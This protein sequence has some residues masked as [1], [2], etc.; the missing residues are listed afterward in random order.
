MF[1]TLC[2]TT[3]A[4]RRLSIFSISKLGEQKL[5]S[6]SKLFGSV[7]KNKVSRK[8]PNSTFQFCD[9]DSSYIFFFQ[10]C[11]SD[12]FLTSLNLDDQQPTKLTNS[13]SYN[14]FK[15]CQFLNTFF[16]FQFLNTFFFFE[17]FGND[18]DILVQFSFT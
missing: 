1:R 6:T 2:S 5:C 14:D 10:I 16:F 17:K 18:V 13:A 9:S 7:P 4:D 8:V 15:T 12:I 3:T 11:T